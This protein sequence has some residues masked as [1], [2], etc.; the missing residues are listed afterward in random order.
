[1]KRL[2]VAAAFALLLCGAASAAGPGSL[3]SFVMVDSSATGLPSAD[4]PNAEGSLALPP[5]YTVRATQPVS[6]TFAELEALW[7]RAGAAYGIP[8]PVLA[9]INK[10]ETNFGQNMGPSS[11]GA[12]GWMQFMPDT[13]LRWG[14]DASGDGVADPWNPEDAVYAAARYLAAAGGRTDIYRGVYAYNHADW[15]VQEV[16]DLAQTYARGGVDVTFPT[17]PAAPTVDMSSLAPLQASLAEA[18]ASAQEL[19]ELEQSF[20]VRATN[21]KLLSD[22]L[23]ARKRAIQVGVQ[24]EQA[25]AD[26]ERLRGEL[27]AAQTGLASASQSSWPTTSSSGVVVLSPTT[28]GTVFPVG[29]GAGTVSVSHHHHDYPAADIA[30]PLG[31]P[32]YAHAAAMVLAAYPE[33]NGRCG[34]GLTMQTADGT[35]WTYCHLQFLEPSVRQGASLAAGAPLGAVGMTGNTTG[36]HLHLQLSPASSYPQEQAWFQQ[37]AGKAFSWQD[38]GAG[39]ERALASARPQPVHPVFA[40]VASDSEDVVAFTR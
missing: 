25:A 37:F 5:D 13:W 2:A 17:V 30:A 9:A 34:I 20:L 26:V 36:P 38:Q 39:S 24:H 40:V 31:S 14:V 18:E 6:R 16:L 7:Q 23:W 8:W 32:I 28:E 11:A 10:V 22:R 29:G 3:G 33:G 1:M 21:A 35:S 15:Y 27:A 12:V 19:A 4:V